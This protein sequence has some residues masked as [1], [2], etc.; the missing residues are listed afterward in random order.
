MGVQACTKKL[1]KMKARSAGKH[2]RVQ[3][4]GGWGRGP[5]WT[6]VQAIRSFVSR[7]LGSRHRMD[8]LST[9]TAAS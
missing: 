3:E 1:A 6:K 4:A 9:K 2:P 5:L 8:G 7:K